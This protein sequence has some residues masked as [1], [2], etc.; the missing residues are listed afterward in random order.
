MLPAMAIERA[1]TTLRGLA[2]RGMSSTSGNAAQIEARGESRAQTENTLPV[3]NWTTASGVMPFAAATSARS[4]AQSASKQTGMCQWQPAADVSGQFAEQTVQAMASA[5]SGLKWTVTERKVGTH[6]TTP[7]RRPSPDRVSS[8]LQKPARPCMAGSMSDPNST[9][10]AVSPTLS[11][12]TGKAEESAVMAVG[13]SLRVEAAQLAGLEDT[14]AT[15]HKGGSPQQD[16]LALRGIPDR[17]EGVAHDLVE[18]HVGSRLPT[19]RRRC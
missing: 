16:T 3:S 10:Q 8:R 18:T 5:C 12:R 17:R 1:G 7:S 2:R 19:R 15:Q 11:R 4:G 6:S 14:L 13:S 9:V